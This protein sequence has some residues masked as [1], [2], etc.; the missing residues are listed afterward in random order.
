MDFF[1]DKASEEDAAIYI[2][3]LQDPM[4]GH[5]TSSFTPEQKDAI[6]KLQTKTD[7]AEL[8][9]SIIHSTA[10]KK[11]MELLVPL[12]MIPSPVHQILEKSKFVVCG[13]Y[14]DLGGRRRILA[15]TLINR[16]EDMT[17]E[18]SE[19]EYYEVKKYCR[20]HPNKHVEVDKYA[21]LIWPSD[22]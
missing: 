12:D 13:E 2:S 21:E 6:N 14:Y 8:W 7:I 9:G 3:H 18:F 11:H 17:H 1:L 19:N 20:E 10:L 4:Y 22:K 16:C 15:Y 5:I